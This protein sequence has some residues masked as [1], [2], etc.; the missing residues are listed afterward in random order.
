MGGNRF[1]KSMPLQKTGASVLPPGVMSD[2]DVMASTWGG[3]DSNQDKSDVAP[4]E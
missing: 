3:R 4:I 1:C 2:G